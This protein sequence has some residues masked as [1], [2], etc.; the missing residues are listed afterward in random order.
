MNPFLSIPIYIK[1]YINKVEIIRLDIEE[2]TIAIPTEPFSSN[3]L[4][5]SNFEVAEF[6][7][8]N[9]IN[10]LVK[11]RKFLGHSFRILIHQLDKIEGGLCSIEKRALRDIGEQVG[12][13]YVVIYEGEKPLSIDDAKIEI[14]AKQ[15]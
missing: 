6:T 3:R 1:I 9:A 15:N 5:I 14:K 11:Q 2:S 4:C 10:E 8:R 12:G 7:I 13:N